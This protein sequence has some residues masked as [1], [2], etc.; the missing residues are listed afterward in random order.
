MDNTAIKVPDTGFTR[1]ELEQFY[2]GEVVDMQ[3]H[4][5]QAEPLCGDFV[6]EIE[7]WARRAMA[8]NG[9]GDF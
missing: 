2:D 4:I 8:S 7:I 6:S 9:F 5:D 1:E 3:L